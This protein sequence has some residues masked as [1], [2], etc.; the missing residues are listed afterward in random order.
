[1]DQLITT[2]GI[3]IAAY[4]GQKRGYVNVGTHDWVQ[5]PFETEIR[6]A[7]QAVLEGIDTGDRD[8]VCGCEAF[9]REET[10]Q[11]C[12]AGTVRYEVL[13]MR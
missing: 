9:P 12:F 3:V 6:Y 1:M 13:A 4:G 8:C 11:G 10:Q 5:N 2:F 7:F